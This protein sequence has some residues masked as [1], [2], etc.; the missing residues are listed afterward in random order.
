MLHPGRIEGGAPA[1]FV[2]SREL[3]VVALARHTYGD[4]SDPRPRIEPREERVKGAESAA[5]VEH[6][7]T[8]R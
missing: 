1:L 7:L 6:T 8:L 3:E 2:I 4:V 5:S